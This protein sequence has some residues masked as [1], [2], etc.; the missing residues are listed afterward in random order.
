MQRKI[1]VF[2][3]NGQVGQELTRT[4]CGT[5][6]GSSTALRLSLSPSRILSKEGLDLVDFGL[7]SG[8]TPKCRDFR[9]TKE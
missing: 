2:G 7:W 1:L 5:V 6:L 9:G 3:A 8:G 4:A